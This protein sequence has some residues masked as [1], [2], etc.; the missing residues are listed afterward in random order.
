MFDA[1]SW[2]R[3]KRLRLALLPVVVATALAGGCGGDARVGARGT[4]TVDGQPLPEGAIHFA[5]AGLQAHTS[6]AKITAGRYEI[7]SQRG[8]KP[9]TYRV[10]IE[11][12]GASGRKVNDP[13]RGPIDELVPVQFRESGE[14]HAMLHANGGN[15][16]DFALTRVLS[17]P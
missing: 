11:A 6:G 14:L 17:A 12:F 5:P 2:Q 15:Q 1:K 4:V 8:L 3:G 10:S 7:A 9:G 16:I 13:E